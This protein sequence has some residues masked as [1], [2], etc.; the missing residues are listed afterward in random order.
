MLQQC[1]AMLVTE[2]LNQKAQASQ[3]KRG[4]TTVAMRFPLGLA[5]RKKQAPGYFPPGINKETLILTE[6]QVKPFKEVH[7]TAC[8]YIIWKD[9][10]SPFNL[11]E[12]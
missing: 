5:P 11:T 1:W 8:H 3:K 7:R 9:I 10:F 6:A 4:L 12:G 2:V